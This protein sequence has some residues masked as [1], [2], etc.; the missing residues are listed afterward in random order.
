[1]GGSIGGFA[2]N[3]GNNNVTDPGQAK[4]GDLSGGEKGA[5]LTSGV[6]Q[7]LG[8]GLQDR[9]RQGAQMRQAQP[10]PIQVQPNP[11]LQNQ[12]D[13]NYLKAFYGR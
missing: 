1:M 10:A 13:P 5:R 2:K 11:V 3:L 6:I 4:W 9:Q 7:G 12:F 8:N